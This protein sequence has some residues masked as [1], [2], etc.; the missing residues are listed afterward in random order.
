[1]AREREIGKRGKRK[2]T[3]HRHPCQ[4]TQYRR[5]PPHPQSEARPCSPCSSFSS[6]ASASAMTTSLLR[7][8]SLSARSPP[9]REGVIRR[10]TRRQ[11]SW[12]ARGRS[13]S[14][15]NSGQDRRKESSLRDDAHAVVARYSRKDQQRLRPW[16]RSSSSC[17]L[18]QDLIIFIINI[19]ILVKYSVI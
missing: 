12:P 16:P 1:M 7:K 19:I 15:A 2:A 18:V 11:P 9:S 3:H 13:S 8:A 6:L 17:A 4:Q 5:Y 14:V 10:G